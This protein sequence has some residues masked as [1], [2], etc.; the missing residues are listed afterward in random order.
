MRA[1]AILV[2][3]LLASIPATAGV[4]LPLAPPAADFVWSPLSPV[5]GEDVLFESASSDDS[6]V[7][8]LYSWRFADEDEPRTG[9][10]SWT[11]RSFPGPG[12]YAVTH[13]VMDATGSMARVT[14][15]VT[16]P[17]SPPRASIEVDTTPTF[18]SM[19]VYFGANV[20]D[21][22]GD[23]I[24]EWRWSFGDGVV[25]SGAN[26]THAYTTIGSFTVT[27]S[28][29]DEA[30]NEA[31]AARIVR[32]LNAPPQ[33]QATYEPRPPVAG[34]PVTFSAVAQD[35]DGPQEA[36]TF[37]WRFSDGM[38]A[39]GATVERT[40]AAAGNQSV[41]LRAKDADGSLSA[42]VVMAFAVQA[43]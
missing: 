4:G 36:I 35:P 24:V 40:Y 10:D 31:H 34:S 20:T 17:N 2:P 43:P 39:S 28:V 37:E 3:L 1:L 8:L 19:D 42:P 5:T 12:A 30:G 21:I 13:E 7:I 32:V 14:K 25:A 41:S 22:D 6:G 38:A 27:L 11:T 29:R 18:R 16:V 15:M 23:D 9:F 33:A 26:V